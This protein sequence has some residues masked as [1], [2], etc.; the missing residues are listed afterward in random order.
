MRLSGSGWEDVQDRGNAVGTGVEAF[1]TVQDQPRSLRK[2]PA[3]GGEGNPRKAGWQRS[4][5]ESGPSRYG[6]ASSTQASIAA[7][8]PLTRT[9]GIASTSAPSGSRL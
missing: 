6:R 7:S 3:T 4:S 8:L 1:G 5:D 9:P 2:T